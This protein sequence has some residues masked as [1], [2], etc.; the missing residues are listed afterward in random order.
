MSKIT[1]F[2]LPMSLRQAY[3]AAVFANGPEDEVAVRIRKQNASND[4]FLRFADATD[5][6]KRASKAKPARIRK[7]TG[8]IN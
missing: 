1:F 4:L 5:R 8:S 2:D 3:M 6:M 7:K